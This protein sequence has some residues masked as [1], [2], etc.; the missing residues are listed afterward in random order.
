MLSLEGK[1]ALNFRDCHFAR[2][3]LGRRDMRQALWNLRNRQSKSDS[4]VPLGL[5]RQLRPSSLT[6]CFVHLDNST[7]LPPPRREI[8]IQERYH[9]HMQG[10]SGLPS[11]RAVVAMIYPDQVTLKKAIA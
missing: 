7:R 2:L 11:R 5:E 6:F 10:I 1:A 9:Q 4:V 8:I 3:L